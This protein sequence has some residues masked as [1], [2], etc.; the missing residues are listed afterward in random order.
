MGRPLRV[1]TL[2]RNTPLTLGVPEEV[3]KKLPQY[4]AV[5]ATLLGR[6]AV[7]NNFRG[8]GLGEKLLMD[9]LYRSLKLSEH[10]ASTGVVGDAK[11]ESGRAF[12][13]KYGSIELPR[14]NRQL[15]MPMGTI[16]KLFARK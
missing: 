9:A 12:Y 14:V 8:K 2:S 6:L 4:P 3:A 5:S 10:V 16:E 1:T 11:D 15:L 7:G 13:Q